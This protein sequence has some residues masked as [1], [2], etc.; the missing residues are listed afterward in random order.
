MMLGVSRLAD[1]RLSVSESSAMIVCFRSLF[2][3]LSSL[4][5]VLWFGAVGVLRVPAGLH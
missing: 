1:V 4:T 5:S 2:G 3:F